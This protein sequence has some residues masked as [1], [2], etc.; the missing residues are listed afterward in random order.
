M[1]NKDGWPKEIHLGIVVDT[2]GRVA[3][4]IGSCLKQICYAPNNHSNHFIPFEDNYWKQSESLHED[5][6][7]SPSVMD[8]LDGTPRPR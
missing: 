7:T 4:F 1:E 2:V 3:E 6:A 8:T 5:G